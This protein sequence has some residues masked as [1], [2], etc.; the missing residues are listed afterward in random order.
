[1]DRTTYT[2]GNAKLLNHGGSDDLSL[3]QILIATIPL[4]PSP[5]L[6]DRRSRTTG[7][8]GERSGRNEGPARPSRLVATCRQPVDLPLRC[9]PRTGRQRRPMFSQSLQ[10][11][12]YGMGPRMR[13]RP[14]RGNRRIRQTA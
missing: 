14:A 3:G 1:M 4:M 10:G 6:N 8:A 12:K 2:S 5:R 13:V 11:K 9:I 7:G